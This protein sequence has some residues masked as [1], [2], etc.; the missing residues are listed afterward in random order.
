MQSFLTSQIGRIYQNF[1]LNVTMGDLRSIDIFVVGQARQPGRYTVSSLSTLA[2]AI[3]ASGG[4]SPTGSMRRIQLKRGSKVIT[5]FDLYDLLIKGDK[6]HDVALQP[7]D[8]VYF[9]AGR[10]Q[11]AVLAARSI[12]LRSTN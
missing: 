1:D 9:L 11:V 7:E 2:N 8:V 4:P 5:E 6:S 12:R 3:F 10:S